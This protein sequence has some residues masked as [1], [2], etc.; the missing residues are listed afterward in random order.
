MT[1]DANEA[2]EQAIAD[3]IARHPISRPYVLAAAGRIDLRLYPP[4]QPL[5]SAAELSRQLLADAEFRSLCLGDW[6]S[7]T[8]GQIIA[9]AVARVLPP[10][11]EPVFS[12]VVDGL[13]FAALEQQ[14]EGRRKAG[15]IAVAS[16]VGGV[17]LAIALSES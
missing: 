17:L 11:Y 7:T 4:P 14:R 2:R 6:L 13:R 5:P 9:A 10:T 12:L 16:I 1:S 15:L 3:Y 8:D